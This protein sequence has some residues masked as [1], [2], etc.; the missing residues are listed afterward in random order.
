[1]LI[2]LLT[3]LWTL[4]QQLIGFIGFLIFHKGYK[5]RYKTAFV[6]EVPNKLGSITL[7]NFIFVSNVKNKQTIK[8]EYGHVRQGYILGLLWLLV[9]GLPSIVWAG[10]F[11]NFRREHNISYYDFYT[12]KW[13]NQLGGVGDDYGR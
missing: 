10:C 2:Y 8:H 3:I 5:G 11:T 9:I 4:P 13:A 12:E 7:G 1:M 6:I